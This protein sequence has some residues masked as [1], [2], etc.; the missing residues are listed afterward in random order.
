[1]EFNELN[2]KELMHLKSHLSIVLKMRT[3]LIKDNIADI[4]IKYAPSEYSLADPSFVM[5][6][7]KYRNTKRVCYRYSWNDSDWFILDDDNFVVTKD[8]ITDC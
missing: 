8:C 6:V 3:Y 5:F 2:K 7:D 4:L 1:M